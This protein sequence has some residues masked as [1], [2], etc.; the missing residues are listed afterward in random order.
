VQQKLRAGKAGYFHY[1]IAGGKTFGTVP[2]PF[3]D[4]PYGNQLLLNDDRAFNL[5]QFMEYGADQ[6]IELNLQHHFEGM[7]MNR[8]PLIKKLKWRSFVFAKGFFGSL[9][10]QNSQSV[11][12]F[13]KGMT[14]FPGQ[15]YEVGFGFENIFKFA[16]M[17]FTWRLTDLNKPNTYFF[18]V[19]PSFVFKF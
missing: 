1:L 6:Y 5:M 15:Y 8:I 10:A 18:I 2:F 7:I 12:L 19:K 17:D 16:R 4:V 11:H 9:S 13:P 14:A 3:L